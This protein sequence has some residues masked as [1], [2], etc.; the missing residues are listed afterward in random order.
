MKGGR[1][2]IV[3]R[4]HHLIEGGFIRHLEVDG[5]GDLLGRGDP[6]QIAGWTNP[7]ETLFAI[8]CALAAGMV[9]IAMDISED[10]AMDGNDLKSILVL[11]RVWL[12]EF[13]HT[14]RT[15]SGE[16]LPLWVP[17]ARENTMQARGGG[18]DNPNGTRQ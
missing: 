13:S 1:C 9:R 17:A 15:G 12:M 5:D 2:G 10:A 14:E 6:A 16:L 3:Q 4:V 7:S 18:L 8:C 11:L